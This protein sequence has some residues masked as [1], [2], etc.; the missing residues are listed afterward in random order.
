[1]L[2]Y[3]TV[4]LKCDISAAPIASLISSSRATLVSFS[5]PTGLTQDSRLLTACS[6]FCLG[7]VTEEKPI[8]LY[9]VIETLLPQAIATS[10]LDDEPAFRLLEL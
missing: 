3:R 1:M 10:I 4:K 5:F 8:F 2:L 7:S 9:E 6:L